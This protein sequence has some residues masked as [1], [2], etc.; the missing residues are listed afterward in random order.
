MRMERHLPNFEG[1][2]QPRILCLVKILIEYE[3]KIKSFSHQQ[4]LQNFPPPTPSRELPWWLSS[5]ESACMQEM[6]V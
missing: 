3:D 1:S 4:G 6:R 2:L 5:K